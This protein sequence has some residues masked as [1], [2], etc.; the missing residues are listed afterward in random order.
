MLFIVKYEFCKAHERRVF[1]RRAAVSAF[2]S[3]D[4]FEVGKAFFLNADNARVFNKEFL[5]GSFETIPPPSSMT[6]TGFT[7]NVSERYLAS[8]IALPP[9]FSSS[10][11]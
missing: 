7:P 11:P 9:E 3:G 2:A 8:A 1:G 10:S 4:E 6:S 5:N